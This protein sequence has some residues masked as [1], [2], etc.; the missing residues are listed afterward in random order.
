MKSNAYSPTTSA[1][2][3][4]SCFQDR[5]F[6]QGHVCT[7]NLLQFPLE[8]TV[9]NLPR[10]HPNNGTVG[11]LA[12]RHFG[13]TGKEMPEGILPLTKVKDEA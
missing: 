1:A 13:K 3:N 2:H 6:C 4:A 8:E 10:F 12:K 9:Q 5:M 11:L 7:I